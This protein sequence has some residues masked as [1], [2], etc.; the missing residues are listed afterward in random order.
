MLAWLVLPALG[1]VEMPDMDSALARA[2]A[3]NRC[4]LVDFTGL[5]WCTACIYLKNH[6]LNAPAFEKE[7]GEQLLLTSVDFPR[8][9][10]LV[11]KISKQER[12]RRESMLAAYRIES[13]PGVVLMD[14]DNMPFGVIYGARRTVAAYAPLVKEAMEARQKRDAAFAQ[15]VALSGF[16]RAQKLAEGLNVLP[17]VCRDKYHA[18][19][20]EIMALDP[21]NKLG[22][23]NMK[24]KAEKRV[25]Q[26]AELTDLLRTFAGKFSQ[27]ELLDSQQK[28]DV[29]LAAPDLDPQ[30]RQRALS[31]KADTY[32][33]L[34]DVDNNILWMQKAYD[35]APDSRLAPKLKINLEYLKKNREKIKNNL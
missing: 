33:F 9:P 20:E 34:R 16:A 6:I 31:A 24:D 21:D 12:V 11:A 19:V 26:N 8:T 25:R 32:A 22:F 27:Q 14:A 29:F 3:E 35:A 5:D 15:A 4:V 10:E 23:H 28:L 18:V 7:F 17:E 13:L 2:K 1:L 30:V